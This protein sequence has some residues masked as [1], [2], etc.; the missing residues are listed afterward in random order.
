M[1]KNSRE[2]REKRRE[3]I[4]EKERGEIMSEEER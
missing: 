3:M 4:E 1:G 2:E